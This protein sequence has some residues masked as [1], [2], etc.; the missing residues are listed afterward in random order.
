MTGTPV[1]TTYTY[2]SAHP[3]RLIKIGSTSIGYNTMGCPTTYNGY[4]ATWT[5]GKLTQ[6][7]K[8]LPL[9][10]MYTYQYNYNAFG[11]RTSYDYTITRVSSAVAVGALTGYSK[12][13]RYD[14][15]GRLI[16]ESK[17]SRYY[18]EGSSTEKIVYL[19]DEC[20]IVGI[21][22]TGSSAFGTYYFQRNLQGDVVAIYSKK[23]VRL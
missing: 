21:T 20:G 13:F 18:G 14:Q 16:Y 4:A 11:Q 3:D 10:G 17:T 19:Y 22:Y 23:A 8:G 7:L 6:L 1:E 5:R 2:D 12:A 9:T 15:S